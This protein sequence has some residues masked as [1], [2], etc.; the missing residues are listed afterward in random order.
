MR[1]RLNILFLGAAKRVSLLE[2]FLDAAERLDV[3]LRIHSFE[4]DS[5]FCP[6]SHLALV[7]EAP[8]FAAAAFQDRL[9]GFYR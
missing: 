7:H 5:G 1:R 8:N 4:K 9:T 2:R 6:I 3:H